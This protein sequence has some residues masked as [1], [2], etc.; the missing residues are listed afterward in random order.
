MT[1]DMFLRASYNVM[2]MDLSGASNLDQ[3]TMGRLEIG[4]RY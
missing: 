2:V 4:W 1:R 3:F